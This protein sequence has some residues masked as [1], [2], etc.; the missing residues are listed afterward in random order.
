MKLSDAEHAALTLLVSEGG[1]VL[2]SAIPDKNDEDVLGNVLPGMRVYVK[3]DKLGLV[4]ITEED[5]I[6]LG[7]GEEFTFTNEVYITDEGKAA[8]RLVA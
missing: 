6:D 4:M 7:D 3:L 1:C 8:L 2:T 5:P